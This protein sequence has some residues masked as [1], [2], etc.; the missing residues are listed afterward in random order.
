ME[1]DQI[2]GEFLLVCSELSAARDRIMKLLSHLERSE[3]VVT[4][5]QEEKEKLIDKV[6]CHGDDLTLSPSHPHTLTPSHPL[7]LTPSQLELYQGENQRLLRK[8]ERFR[9]EKDE[10][11]SVCSEV[12][13]REREL[14]EQCQQVCHQ[15]IV[16]QYQV[17]ISS[18]ANR[19]W[20]FE[21]PHLLNIV[22][23]LGN[24]RYCCSFGR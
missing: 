15:R 3:K 8:I 19:W 1:Y 2:E 14:E 18:S 5:T 20:K 13:D 9:R 16:W 11:E 6:C 10:G 22:D 24:S 23:L 21:V 17:K 7:T 4:I 12:G